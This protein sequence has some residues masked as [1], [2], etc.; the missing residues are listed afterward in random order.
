MAGHRLFAAL[1]LSQQAQ[2]TRPWP[3]MR[4]QT[5]SAGEPSRRRWWQL[6]HSRTVYFAITQHSFHWRARRP[7]WPNRGWPRRS[8]RRFRPN[9]MPYWADGRLC[10]LAA[11]CVRHALPR[12]ASRP[13]PVWA[14]PTHSRLQP[15][16]ARAGVGRHGRPPRSGRGHAV[17]A[18]FRA[19]RTRSAATVW[20]LVV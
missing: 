9:R 10:G 11:P 17:C 15:R 16:T 8:A 4:R 12:R 20:S 5:N 7:D 6:E 13:V 2:H 14:V 18:C 19:S 1:I 3:S